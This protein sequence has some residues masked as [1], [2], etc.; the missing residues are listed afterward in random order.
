MPPPDAINSPEQIPADLLGE[1]VTWVFD[2]DNTMYPASVNMFDQIDKRMCIFI[3]DFLDIDH[4]SAYRVQKQ[5]FREHGSSLKGLMDLHAMEPGPFLDYVH[6]IDVTCVSPNH[7][8]GDALSS[9]PGR[10]FIY[11]NA[12]TAHAQRVLGQLGVAHH[13]E[14]VFDIVDAD[15]QPKPA[16]APYQQLIAEQAIEPTR[17]VMVED[18]ARNLIPAAA[19]GMTTVWVHSDR[20]W[21]GIEGSSFEPDFK[22]TD[23]GDWL[24]AITR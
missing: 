10:K 22:I 14:A 21:A 8:M 20:P 15:F 17:A 2:L 5:Y 1:D 19:L 4:Q 6:D 7:Q 3:A 24:A 12:T 16:P 9:L 18:V 23:L 11:T 13:I